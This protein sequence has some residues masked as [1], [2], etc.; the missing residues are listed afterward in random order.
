MASRVECE[1]EGV[2]DV[3]PNELKLGAVAKGAGLTPLVTAVGAGTRN[4]V[5]IKGQ[6]PQ[7]PHLPNFCG[8]MPVRLQGR[9]SGASQGD[10][11]PWGHG[12]P[13]SADQLSLTD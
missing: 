3:Q 2:V 12:V 10:G 13:V 1:G 9:A 6:K 11:E 5:N 7:M 8:G 4:A